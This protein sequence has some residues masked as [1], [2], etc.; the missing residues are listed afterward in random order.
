MIV[1]VVRAMPGCQFQCELDLP[2]GARVEDAIRACGLLLSF[3]ELADAPVGV[4]GRL[5]EK[6]SLL[7]DG[8]RV[9]FYRP[10]ALEPGEARRARL[11][12]GR[13]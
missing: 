10:L 1:R 9:E 4:H 13:G 12:N 7:A 2:E 11:R 3:P 8:D 6:N 5:V